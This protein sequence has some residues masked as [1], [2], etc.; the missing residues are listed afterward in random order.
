MHNC[1]VC[2]Q[3]ESK[4]KKPVPKG[5]PIEQTALHL[6]H[7][8]CKM[9]DPDGLEQHE[10]AMPQEVSRSILFMTFIEILFNLF[11]IDL[12]SIKH[13]KV[14]LSLLLPKTV[15]QSYITFA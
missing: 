14:S 6:Q 1:D 8:Y 11:S 15:G 7:N 10:S 9:T 2:L 5:Q 3:Q 4:A 12:G 13:W